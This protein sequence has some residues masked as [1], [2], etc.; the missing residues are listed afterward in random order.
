MP[1]LT[2]RRALAIGIVGAGALIAPQIGRRGSVAGTVNV[3]N[4][5]EY[6][7]RDTVAR[8]EA[9]TGIKAHYDFYNSNEEMEAK[10]LAGLSGYDVV[11]ASGIGI[12]RLVHAGVVQA[13]DHNKLAGWNRLDPAVMGLMAPLDPGHRHA[14]PYLWGTTGFTYNRTLINARLPDADTSSVGLVFDP[15]NAALLADCGISMLDSPTDVLRLAFALLNIDADHPSPADFDAAI[16][17]FRPI[18]RY[19]RTF[20]STSYLTTIPNGDVC[21]IQS[22][23]GIYAISSRRAAEAGTK[24][25]LV[26]VV[27]PSGTAAWVDCFVI[28]NDAP[29]PA[30]AHK[31]LAWMLRPDSAAAASQASFHATA[32]R[33]GAMLVEPSI[34]SDPAIYPPTA[35][36]A[37]LRVGLPWSP[38]QEREATRAWRAIKDGTAA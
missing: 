26:Y 36:V 13:L 37:R 20:D 15:A 10:L 12:P 21:A 29:D 25:D 27:P 5:A 16:N 19:I 17:L 2:R 8:F 24:L 30:N 31:F 18:R 23:S 9:T 38:E 33:A 14:M 35:T 1:F 28:P 22:Y 7:G 11:L 34:R 6:I 3:L 4:W 32:N